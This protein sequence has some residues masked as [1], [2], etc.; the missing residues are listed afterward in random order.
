VKRDGWSRR[1]NMFWNVRNL[2]GYRL[3]QPGNT[4]GDI[5]LLSVAAGVMSLF[6]EFKTNFETFEGKYDQ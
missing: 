5:F 3:L 6:F 1:R 4:G 2:D